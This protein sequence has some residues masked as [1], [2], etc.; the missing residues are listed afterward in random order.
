MTIEEIKLYSVVLLTLSFLALSYLFYLL[1]KNRNNPPGTR[2][3][4][5]KSGSQAPR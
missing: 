2:R 4:S 1:Y 3:K 5:R